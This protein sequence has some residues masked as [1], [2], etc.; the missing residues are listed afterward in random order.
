M[1]VKKSI[2]FH[3]SGSWVSSESFKGE[4]KQDDYQRIA[5]KIVSDFSTFRD[6]NTMSWNSR[7]VEIKLETCLDNLTKNC[8]TTDGNGAIQGEDGTMETTE[9]GSKKSHSTLCGPSDLVSPASVVIPRTTAKPNQGVGNFVLLSNYQNKS[10]KEEYKK[11]QSFCEFT[12]HASFSD[13]TI[14]DHRETF[15]KTNPS[16][17]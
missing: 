7:L 8:F 14:E 16:R 10:F 4:A 13:E 11:N 3:S 6:V 15:Y 2:A 5:R 1:I 9:M 12:M 17:F